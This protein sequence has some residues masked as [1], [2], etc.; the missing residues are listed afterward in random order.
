MMKRFGAVLVVLSVAV[1]GACSSSGGGHRMGG[2]SY[3]SVADEIVYLYDVGSAGGMMELEIDRNGTIYEAEAD[4]HPHQVPKAAMDAVMAVSGGGTVT[5]AEIEFGA[6]GMAYEVKLDKGG[7]GWEFVVTEDGVILETEQ[8]IRRQDAPAMV[9]DNAL[10]AL[11]GSFKSV[12]IITA[13]DHVLYHVKTSDGVVNY[14]A[15]VGVDG[16]VWRAVREARAEIE[17]PLAR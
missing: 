15:V 5:G 4:I 14:K 7:V 12:E 1:L 10:A 13:G 16:E 9:I 11:P 17:I 6:D 3:G 2:G 8:T